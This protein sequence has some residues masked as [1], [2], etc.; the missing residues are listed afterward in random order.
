MQDDP[1]APDPDVARALD[2]WAPMPPPA[3]FAD[4]VVAARPAAPEL[5]PPRRRVRLIGGIAIALAGAAAAVTVVALRSPYRAASDT[6]HAAQRTTIALGGRGIAVAEPATDLTWRVADDGAAEITQRTG[7]VFYRVERGGPFVVHTPA[8]DVRVTGTCFRVEVQAMTPNQK[9][10]I[11]GVT[12]AAIASAVLI[13]VYEGR[14]IAETASARTELAAGSQATL[15][16]H[17][18]VLVAGTVATPR[19]SLDPTELATATRDQLVARAQVQ[20]VELNRLRARVAQLETAGSE[21]VG[22]DVPEPGRV[23][24]DPSPEKLAEWVATCHVRTDEPAIDRFTP[25]T[26]PD[27]SRGLTA[28]D[29]DDYNAAVTDV[30]KRFKDL[31][32][33]LY[34][35]ITGDMTGADSLSSESMRREI[36][37]KSPSGEHNLI[38][39]RISRERAGLAPPPADLSKTSPLE[40]ITRAYVSLGDQTEAAL[41]KR[42]GPERAHAIRGEGW[43]ARYEMGGCPAPPAGN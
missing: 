42:F 33:S 4:R 6:V 10:L 25:R 35:E 39:Q 5:P 13:T 23:W 29:L 19:A 28:G 36:D 40:R 22:V 1:D 16:D 20:Q 21:S 27:P 30:Q 9:L 37:D 24:H 17:D 2:A 38:L 7:N 11:A 26:E 34:I 41:A 12:G 18:P 32:R 15:R 14:V 43:N 8:G 3:G 31:V